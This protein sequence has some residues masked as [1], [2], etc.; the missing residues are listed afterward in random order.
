M[1]DVS[2]FFAA[3]GFS[4]VKGYPDDRAVGVFV[5]RLA[6]ELFGADVYAEH[7]VCLERF[8]TERTRRRSSSDGLSQHARL[9]M[10]TMRA[11]DHVMYNLLE[12]GESYETAWV[13]AVVYKPKSARDQS[14]AQIHHPSSSHQRLHSF[15]KLKTVG[16]VWRQQTHRW[17]PTTLNTLV[18]K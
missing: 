2:G 10:H 18:P 1:G 13:F 11:G 3:A 7:H 4:F 6:I 16:N 9:G 8:N 17:I 12:D 5:G 14:G 15:F